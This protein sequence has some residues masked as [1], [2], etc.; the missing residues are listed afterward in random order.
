[1]VIIA[2][3]FSA[4]GMKVYQIIPLSN[5]IVNELIYYVVVIVFIVY[6]FRPRFYVPFIMLS[7]YWVAS[8]GVELVLVSLLINTMGTFDPW[9]Y[10]I[11]LIGTVAYI[12]GYFL[13]AIVA[14][15]FKA[16]Y[17]F[18]FEIPRNMATYIVVSPMIFVVT[19]NL[20]L[21][22]VLGTGS[23]ISSYINLLMGY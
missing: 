23:E 12:M 20:V 11:Q 10:E 13:I 9:T 19:Y 5:L 2:L 16:K 8:A 7:V 18:D 1:M 15:R 17:F 21:L 22:R 3:S 6:E 14:G 4:L